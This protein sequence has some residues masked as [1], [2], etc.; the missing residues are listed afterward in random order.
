MYGSMYEIIFIEYYINSMENMIGEVFSNNMGWIFRSYRNVM[1][2]G[3]RRIYI[4][5]KK[6]KKALEH[7]HGL[8]TLK[9]QFRNRIVN[10]KH[11]IF[12]DAMDVQFFSKCTIKHVWNMQTLSLDNA[13][14]FIGK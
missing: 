9:D 14:S 3:H 10:N 1:F 7:N 2:P 6:R 8:S 4:W 11:D 12:D 13:F 5:S